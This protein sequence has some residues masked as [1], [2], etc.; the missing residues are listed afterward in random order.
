[1]SAG[2]LAMKILTE[3]GKNSIRP[4]QD[5]RQ[6][7]RDI[8]EGE[9][10]RTEESRLLV[11][12]PRQQVTYRGLPNTDHSGLVDG[13]D[14]DLHLGHPAC[15]KAELEQGFAIVEIVILALSKSQTLE[16]T[17]DAPELLNLAP[18]VVIFV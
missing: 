5:K 2:A 16:P 13:L 12:N 8:E 7:E 17:V 6:A 11:V 1:M 15:L 14:L 10:A 3:L 4:S 18:P 9:V